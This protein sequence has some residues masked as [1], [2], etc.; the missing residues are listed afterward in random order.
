MRVMEEIDFDLD[1]MTLGEA[2]AAED[3]SGQ[4]IETLIV[5]A[6]RRR[7]LAV[8]VSRLRSSGRAP[9]WSDLGALRLV[10]SFSGG[11]RSSQDNPSAISETSD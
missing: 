8:F 10:D 4:S 3:A 1:T 7:M 9:L 5:T 11:S 2:V 6:A